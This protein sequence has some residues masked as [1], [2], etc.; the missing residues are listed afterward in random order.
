MCHHII[1][2]LRNRINLT[3]ERNLVDDILVD[4]SRDRIILL[5]MSGDPVV[6]GS[7]HSGIDE[8]LKPFYGDIDTVDIVAARH[9]GLNF[10]EIFLPAS[11]NIDRLHANSRLIRE[12]L[13]TRIQS[14]L[15]LSAAQPGQPHG[16][17]APSGGSAGSRL[18]LR[19]L[20]L[21]I[22]FC[23]LLLCRRTFFF[24]SAVCSCPV[25]FAPTACESAYCQSACQYHCQ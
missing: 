25:F 5:L 23:R 8:H 1:P 10:G 21:C 14:L 3:V 2:L 22:P 15:V 17:I 16:H 7:R 12:L 24:R 18:L 11:R 19:R 20:H 4:I 6:D 13:Q 9:H